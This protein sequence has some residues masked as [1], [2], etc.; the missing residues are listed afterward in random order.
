LL[1]VSPPPVS[2]PLPVLF[3]HIS[4]SPPQ[5]LVLRRSVLGAFIEIALALGVFSLNSGRPLVGLPYRHTH[6]PNECSRPPGLVAMRL[7]SRLLLSGLVDEAGWLTPLQSWEAS[8]GLSRCSTAHIFCCRSP[9]N[10]FHVLLLPFPAQFIL[11]L[12][13]LSFE[14]FGSLMALR[15]FF[16]FHLTPSQSSH[17]PPFD[18]TRPP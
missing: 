5:V 17:F 8:P 15:P 7:P 1:H 2:F 4:L 13:Q 9:T 16:F 12:G 11:S 6:R 3:P 18:F 14:A 10:R